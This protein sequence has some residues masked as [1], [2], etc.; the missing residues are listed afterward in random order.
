MWLLVSAP[1][2][3]DPSQTQSWLLVGLVTVL[4]A[5][6]LSS[7]QLKSIQGWICSARREPSQQTSTAQSQP[8]LA[9]TCPLL[10]PSHVQVPG[11]QPAEPSGLSALGLSPPFPPSVP[12]PGKFLPLSTHKQVFSN[13]HQSLFARLCEGLTTEK[14]PTSSFRAG[15]LSHTHFILFWGMGSKV[16]T[17]TSHPTIPSMGDA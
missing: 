7:I 1:A 13:L 2:G 10:F 6:H 8:H 12:S 14:K 15:G 9:L 5:V 4:A 16:P 17:S 11:S 3:A